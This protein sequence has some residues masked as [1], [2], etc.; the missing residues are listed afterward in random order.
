METIKSTKVKFKEY[1]QNQIR[2]IPLSLDEMI[3]KNYPVK[4]VHY[5]EFVTKQV[6]I[7]SFLHSCDVDQ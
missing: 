6:A 4:D 3:D 7:E 5:R 2:L 1:A